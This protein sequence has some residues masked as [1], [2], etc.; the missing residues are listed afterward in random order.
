[1]KLLSLQLRPFGGA[2]DRTFCF[3]EKIQSLEGPNEF[4]KSTFFKALS[5]V[6]FTN[7]LTKK[8]CT[9]VFGKWFPKGGG[10]YVEI[11]VLNLGELFTKSKNDGVK[12]LLVRLSIKP[13]T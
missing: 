1:M 7:N 9:D 3:T 10:D 5:H 2:T 8:R 11:A 6:L 4:G 13:L 12:I